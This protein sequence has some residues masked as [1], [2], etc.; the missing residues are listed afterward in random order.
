MKRRTWLAV[1][2]VVLGGSVAATVAVATTS[3]DHGRSDDFRPVAAYTEAF[4]GDD[5]SKER[6]VPRTETR[7]FSLLGVSWED[8]KAELD[9]TAQIRT[10]SA[11]T[12]AWTK[13]QDLDLGIRPPE[14]EEGQDGGVR[15][16]S[17]PLWVGKS[18]AVE[19]RVVAD[20]G[21]TA[22]LPDG[23]RLDLI[24][25]GELGEPGED[26]GGGWR[27]IDGGNK[28]E[29]T[30][31]PSDEP[32]P[33]TSEPTSEPT[34][35]PTDTPTEEPTGEPTD[36]PTGEPTEEPTDTPT[37]EPTTEPTDTPTGEPTGE[38][39]DTPTGEPTEEPT[40]TPTSEPT[41]EPTDTPTGEPTGEPTDTPTGEPTEEPTDTPTS[42]PTTE[43]TDT[44]TEE[45]T[46][47]PTD[48]PTSPEPTTEPT[49]AG[50]P[51]IVSR[52]EWGADESLVEDPPSYL[53]RVDA[54]FVHHTAGTNNYACA[55]SAAVVR[56]I[57]TYHVKTNGWNDI[58]YNFFVDK[59]GT[60][61][62]GR[63]GGVDKA[64]RGAHT[65]GFN[66]YSSG[67]TV[68]GNYEDGARPT[69]AALESVAR[70]SA[71]KLGLHGVDPAGEVTLTAAADTGVWKNGERATLHRI[72][73]HRDGYAT[74]CPGANLYSQLPNI[75]TQAAAMAS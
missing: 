26:I 10:R 35:E 20:S 11:E 6:S 27:K 5:G 41:T 30:P 67:V 65:Y 52:A 69:R 70:I 3:D 4:E 48:T 58:G 47:E 24:D 56:G 45:P 38:P 51:E 1:G 60:I 63:A 44:P 22:E 71:W 15:G 18:D 68:L 9:G 23:L 54:V 25:P 73:G 43:P 19:A 34:T 14:T 39:T 17:E 40:D 64:V 42:E 55:D 32:E 28:D 66:G 8:P 75:R 59:C 72:S 49:D 50:V 7:L 2:S 12:G 33:G 16:A 21:K 61:F 13:W 36:T 37:S 74:L 57:L 62:E 31:E 53:D 46:G 29:G